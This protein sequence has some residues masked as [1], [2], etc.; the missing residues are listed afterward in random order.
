VRPRAAGRTRTGAREREALPGA[1]AAT[2]P[3]GDLR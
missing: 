1:A 2:L 3:V